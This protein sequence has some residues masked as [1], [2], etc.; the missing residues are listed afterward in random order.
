[1][2]AGDEEERKNEQKK[3]RN[4]CLS[5]SLMLTR[6]TCILHGPK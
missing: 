3:E 4:Q 6:V 2:G 1:M 5:H